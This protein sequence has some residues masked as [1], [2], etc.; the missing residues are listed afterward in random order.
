M[1]LMKNSLFIILLCAPLSSFC[2]DAKYQF[3]L[4]EHIVPAAFVLVAGAA[5]GINQALQF[6]YDGFKRAFPGAN[7][8]FYNPAISWTNKYKDHDPAKGEAFL[9][10]KTV[11]VFTTDAYHLSRFVNHLFSSGAIAVKIGQK[12]EKWFVYVLQGLSYWVLH[13][14]SF[15]LVYS[16]F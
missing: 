3:K 4:K 15:T 14:L 8:Q 16:R 10:S 9:G 12:R 13:R 2:Q 11:F 7:D 5:D 6:R 1:I